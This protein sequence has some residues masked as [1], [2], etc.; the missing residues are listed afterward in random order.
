MK[1]LSN[2][3]LELG[4]SVTE[5]FLDDAEL[6]TKLEDRIFSGKIII[7]SHNFRGWNIAK[8]IRSKFIFYSTLD[9]PYN[10]ISILKI[11]D[12]R[13]VVSIADQT[14]L[15]ICNKINPK[16]H[17][18]FSPAFVVLFDELKESKRMSQRNID[19]LF[20]G[21]LGLEKIDFSHKSFLERKLVHSITK[22]AFQPGIRQIHEIAIS[23]F[24]LFKKM[25]LTKVDFTSVEFMDYCWKLAHKV[26]SDRRM[27]VLEELFRLPKT[28]KICFVTDSAERISQNTSENH[29]YLPFQEW[30]KVVEIMQDTKI[31]INVQPFHLFGLHERICTAMALGSVVLTDKNELLVKKYKEYEN[32]LFFDYKKGDLKSKLEYILDKSLDLDEMS[33]KARSLTLNED[34]PIHRMKILIDF[35]DTIQIDNN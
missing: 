5:M 15:E 3:L 27:F 17:F 11:L 13:C 31:V 28:M 34:L 18:Y 30:D 7:I 32:I 19:V 21:R 2:A 20:L 33:Q 22:D 26:R 35:I 24:L 25:G 23:K 16:V 6:K 8:E 14:H 4:Y 9:T 10:K 1:V 29:T 12:D